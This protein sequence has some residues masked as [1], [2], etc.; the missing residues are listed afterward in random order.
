MSQLRT[1]L[2]YYLALSIGG[3]A[4]LTLYLRPVLQRL[5][6]QATPDVENLELLVLA[7]GLGML[8]LGTTTFFYHII[9]YRE[10]THYQIIFQFAGM[11]ANVVLNFLLVPRY[12]IIGAGIATFFCY[13][14]IAI[15]AIT[16]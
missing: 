5:L 7:I 13:T 14:A 11:A 15:A 8:S 12:G 10:I 9:R 2:G 6:G 16:C 1:G 4:G 3:L